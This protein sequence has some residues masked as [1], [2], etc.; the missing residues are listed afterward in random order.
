VPRV[1][2]PEAVPEF[3]SDEWVEAL[4][5]AARDAP[6]LDGLQLV[7]Q[8]IVRG[9]APT[10]HLY[11]L[12]FEEGGLRVRPGRHADPDVTVVTDYETAVAIQRAQTTAL[13]AL[14]AGRL[15]LRGDPSALLRG[16]RALARV[17]DLFAVV[18]ASTSFPS[19]RSSP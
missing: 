2:D 6:P 13:G 14:A 8:Q 5:A 4:D 17:P 7:L 1:R 18:R 10:E 3:L 9:P 16:A 11:A 12:V 19:L 15:E